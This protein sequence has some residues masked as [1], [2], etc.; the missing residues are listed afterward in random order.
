MTEFRVHMSAVS[1]FSITVEAEDYDE[2]IDK[3]IEE[4]SPDVCAQCA[5]WRR[6]WSLDL[7]ETW[8]ADAVEDS[9]GKEVW[10]DRESWQRRE[11]P[12]SASG[13]GL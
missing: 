3:A 6:K 4:R 11:I 10:A 5:G 7:G 8:E 13:G 1:S 2:A 9:D 12:G